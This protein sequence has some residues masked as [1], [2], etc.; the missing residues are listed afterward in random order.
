MKNDKHAARGFTLVELIIAMAIG[1]VV[2]GALYSLFSVQ[3][4]TFFLQE[5]IAEMQQNARSGMEIMLRDIRMAGYNPKRI[6]PWISGTEPG[7]T[8][9]TA[10][11]LSYVSD[12]NADGDTT[13]ASFNPKENITYDTYNDGGI[14]F[15]GRTTN[16]VR[17]PVVKNIESMTL[18]Y[19]D[20]TGNTLSIP[21]SLPAVRK[22]RVTITTKTA[23]PDSSY[24][25]TTYGDHYRRYSLTF[26]VTPRNLGL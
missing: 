20:Q 13:A 4:Q 11:S 19:Y 15:L 17:Q 8:G 3:N 22:I 5:Q 16:G 6:T 25:D 23:L 10:N 18:V 12:L 9:A 24:A 26:D 14:S 1:M 21:L 7:L 2:L